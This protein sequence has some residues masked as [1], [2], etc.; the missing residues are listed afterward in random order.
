VGGVNLLAAGAMAGNCKLFFL[1]KRIL[2]FSLSTESLGLGCVA[3]VV[4]LSSI[5]S[6]IENK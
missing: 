4:T 2:S 3:Q 1:A 5:V 6:V